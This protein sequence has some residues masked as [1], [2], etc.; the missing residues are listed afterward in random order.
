MRIAALGT[1]IT[2]S[3]PWTRVAE[4]LSGAL[5]GPVEVDVIAESGVTSRWGLRQMERVIS[6]EPDVVMIEF[7]MNDAN[8][9]RFVSREESR[10][11][12]HAMVKRLRTSLPRTA[13]TVVVTNPVHRLRGLMRPAVRSYYGEYRA[14]ASAE[15]I[16]LVDLAPAWDALSVQAR[17]EAIPDGV[18]PSS[19]ANDAIVAPALVAALTWIRKSGKTPSQDEIK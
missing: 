3:I 4:G 16:G 2:A 10:R 13:V 8:W 9:R 14:L 7:C 17:R 5:R 19:E 1:S 15:R 11:N 12:A 6:L 18:H